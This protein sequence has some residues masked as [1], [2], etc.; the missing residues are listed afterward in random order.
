MANVHRVTRRPAS[1]IQEE[2]LSFLVSIEY[3]F[4]IPFVKLNRERN[5]PLTE[6]MTSP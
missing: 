1:S 6:E 4:E 2:R 5:L 3:T